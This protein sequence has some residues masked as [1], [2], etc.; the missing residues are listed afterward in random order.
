MGPFYFKGFKVGFDKSC[1]A[2]FQEEVF[3][4]GCESRAVFQLD[5]QEEK[6]STVQQSA[7]KNS[8]DKEQKC[9][10]CIK[11][12]LTKSSIP[13]Q[14]EKH[15]NLI[16]LIH[17]DLYNFIGVSDGKTNIVIYMWFFQLLHDL[18]TE[19]KYLT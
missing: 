14:S 7:D 10:I 5:F 9:E 6:V 18:S 1:I 4:T 3:I 19:R 13:R 8:N 2:S 11:T 17:I 16:E 15:T 12:T